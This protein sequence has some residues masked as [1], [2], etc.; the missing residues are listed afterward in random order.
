MNSA[1]PGQELDL[2]TLQGTFPSIVWTFCFKEQTQ[3]W[4]GKKSYIIISW[5]QPTQIEKDYTQWG[6]IFTALSQIY[7]FIRFILFDFYLFFFLGEESWP[8]ANIHCQSS[9]I[10]YVGCRHSMAWWALCRSA[11][12]V[13]THKP[14][15][16][17]VEHANL[18]TMPLGRLPKFIFKCHSGLFEMSAAVFTWNVPGPCPTLCFSKFYL[19]FKDQREPYTTPPKSPLWSSWS[20]IPLHLPKGRQRSKKVTNEGFSQTNLG[21]DPK[22]AFCQVYRFVRVIYP[23]GKIVCFFISCLVLKWNKAFLALIV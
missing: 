23:W 8:W 11:P 14:W 22:S 20:S 5:K 2:L 7:L 13:R 16:A 19:A 4:W 18:T 12:G 6:T 1:Q 17:K 15:A 21:L 10:L 9:S 3:T